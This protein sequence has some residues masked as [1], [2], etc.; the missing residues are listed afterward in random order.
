MMRM[1]LL[2]S[3][4]MLCGMPSIAH[5]Q[6]AAPPDHVS[7]MPFPDD[8]SAVACDVPQPDSALQVITLDSG[9]VS[10]A[11]PRTLSPR[12]ARVDDGVW[13]QLW[14]TADSASGAILTAQIGPRAVPRVTRSIGEHGRAMLWDPIWPVFRDAVHAERSPGS[15]GNRHRIE[16]SDCL[17]VRNVCRTRISGQPIY[18][19]T[20]QLDGWAHDREGFAVWDLGGERRLVITLIGLTEADRDALLP[21]FWTVHLQPRTAREVQ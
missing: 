7:S 11:L 13:S 10:L 8:Y 1:W 15:P 17:V 12:H 14:E 4:A 19:A 2:L 20:G 3:T 6:H 21:V 9:R 18:I 16:C 5:G